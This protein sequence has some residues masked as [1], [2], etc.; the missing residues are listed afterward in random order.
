MQVSNLIIE[1]NLRMA[2]VRQ[3]HALVLAKIDEVNAGQYWTVSIRIVGAIH[4]PP[5]AEET[6]N[7]CMIGEIG[8]HEA[9]VQLVH[10]PASAGVF[11]GIC[12]KGMN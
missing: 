4:E 3:L 8:G 1:R 12:R 7:F 9:R 2:T 11:P 5:P 6:R 10:N